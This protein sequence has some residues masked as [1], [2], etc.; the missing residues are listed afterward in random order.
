[1]TVVLLPMVLLL[2][3]SG[4]GVPGNPMVLLLLLPGRTV[5]GP[6]SPLL[7][8]ERPALVRRSAEAAADE[9]ERHPRPTTHGSCLFWVAAGRSLRPVSRSCRLRSADP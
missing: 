1:M 4:P 6:G 9:E 7:L 3:L 8:T 2:L 5:S